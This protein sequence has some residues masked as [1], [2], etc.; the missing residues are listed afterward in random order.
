MD[1]NRKRRVRTWGALRRACAIAVTLSISACVPALTAETPAR[2]VATREVRFELS[3]GIVGMMKQMTIFPDGRLVAEN[4]RRHTRVEKRLSS[5]ELW[6]LHRLLERAE[7]VPGT[8]MGF[9]SRCADCMQYRLTV[10]QSG[11][12]TTVSES[13]TLGRQRPGNPELTKLLIT[14]L[15]KAIQP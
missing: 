13:G 7:S 6:E 12:K 1:G 10:V 4:L 14:I 3:G 2:T 15:N 9:P 8:V 5:D 11:G